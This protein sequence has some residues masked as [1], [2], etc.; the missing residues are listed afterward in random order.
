M[1][2][3]DEVEERAAFAAIE[4]TLNRLR[5]ELN[6]DASLVTHVLGSA[7][8]VE[9]ASST[10]D[11]SETARA[12]AAGYFLCDCDTRDEALRILRHAFDL[13]A[14]NS[15]EARRERFTVHD[16]SKR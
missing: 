16:G 15:A 10:G 7:M 2:E 11:D 5:A 1:K 9:I 4:R 8:L 14:A 6:G 13:F 12:K 3:N